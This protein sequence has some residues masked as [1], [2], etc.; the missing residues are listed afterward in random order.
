MQCIRPVDYYLETELTA[1]TGDC[2]DNDPEEFPGQVWYKD[3]DNDGYS[4][5]TI[6]NQCARPSGYKIA[7]AL[8]ALS[9]DCNDANSAINP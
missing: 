7:S 5:G 3:M 2:N 4:D 9:G 1:T 8:I 6:L